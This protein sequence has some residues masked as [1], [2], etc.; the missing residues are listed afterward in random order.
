MMVVAGPGMA[1]RSPRLAQAAYGRLL[2]HNELRNRSYDD[3]VEEP[4]THVIDT[5]LINYLFRQPRPHHPA[6]T[7]ID[8]SGE[9]VP[10]ERTLSWEQLSARVQSVAALLQELSAPGDRVAIIARQD[11]N[12]V[13]AFLG[14]LYAG[15]IAVPLVAPD[16]GAQRNR[17]CSALEDCTPSVWL[18][19]EDLQPTMAE[20]MTEYEVPPPHVL[21]V[22]TVSV[23]SDTLPPADVTPT[24]PAYLQYSSGSTR[25]P[26]AAVI[27]HRAL[28]ASCW[29]ASQAYGVDETTTCVGWIPFSHDMGLIQLLCVPVFTRA[30]SVFLAPLEFVRRPARWLQLMS[31]YPNVF[32]AAPNFAFDLVVT[33]TSPAMRKSLDLSGVRIALNGSEPVRPSTITTFAETFGPYG[34]TPD[35]HRPSYGLAEATVYVSSAG[36]AGPRITSFDSVE[37]G[38]GRAVPSGAGQASE[39]VSVGRPFGQVIRIVDKDQ[40]TVL[41]EGAIG[42]I[43]VHGPHVA[44]GY[45]R[46]PDATAKMFGARISGDSAGA[47]AEGWLR[48]GDLG[49]LYEGELYVTGRIKDLIIADGRNHYPQDIETTVAA[50]HPVIRGDR[51]AAFSV[52]DDDGEGVVVVAEHKRNCDVP[53]HEPIGRAVRKAVSEQHGLAL[54]AFR[55]LAPGSVMRTSSGKV[56]RSAT[57]ERVWGTQQDDGE[58]GHG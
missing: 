33:A 16:G 21:A 22:D 29:Q 28:S 1:G 14:A 58:D 42:E 19:S 7:Y 5:P 17:L 53:D 20:F 36:A 48:T 50:A 12:Y 2:Q 54:L 46:R 37:L 10:T 23:L 9:A 30:R 34:F 39:L 40:H 51:V 49:L 3:R 24:D 15:R 32:T 6:F 31:D 26:A 41:P 25:T 56:A 38:N 18:V 11:L 57:R 44:F 35:A 47:P 55:L 45:W 4:P 27:T 8:C 13:I 43:W 52:H